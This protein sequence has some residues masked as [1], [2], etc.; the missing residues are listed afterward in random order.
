MITTELVIVLPILVAF[1]FMLVLAGRLTDARSDVVGAANDAARAASLQRNQDA[2]QAQAQAAARDTVAGERLSCRREGPTVEVD[3][4][5]SG[6]E[7]EVA[8]FGR[9]ADV[10]V[11]VTC[12]SAPRAKPSGGGG[13]WPGR[14][15]GGNALTSTVGAPSLPMQWRRSPNTVSSA[16]AWAWAWAVARLVW[17]DAARAAS[18]AAPT[19]SL[20]ASVSRPARISR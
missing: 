2:A 7:G 14:G 15:L 13:G 8:P 5:R 10:R 6:T 20:R 11:T 1:L 9:G 4:V 3:T 12:T 18:L 17:S 19:T 16:A